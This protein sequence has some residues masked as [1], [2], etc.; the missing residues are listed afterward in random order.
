MPQ[1]SQEQLPPLP[2]LADQASRARSFR[3]VLSEA[4]EPACKHLMAKVYNAMS[5]EISGRDQH[6][7]ALRQ[8]ME[9][10]KAQINRVL[11]DPTAARVSGLT[12]DLERMASRL[13]EAERFMTVSFQRK[14]LL[15]SGLALTRP[16]TSDPNRPLPPALSYRLVQALILAVRPKPFESP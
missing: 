1:S 12:H 11:Q 14:G 16:P 3:D 4:A 2:A 7:A 13:A 9:T 10:R 6:L 5:K 8:A 15:F